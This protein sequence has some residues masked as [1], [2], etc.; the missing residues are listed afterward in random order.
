MTSKI[1]AHMIL[2]PIFLAFIATLI[3]NPTIAF[4]IF[5]ATI[6]VVCIVVLYCIIHDVISDS[7]SSKQRKQENDRIQKELNEKWD[8]IN[9]RA[10]RT[11]E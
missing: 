10:P 2:A 7:I 4:L 11:D 8:L 9:K 1:K 6:L 3:I 5:V